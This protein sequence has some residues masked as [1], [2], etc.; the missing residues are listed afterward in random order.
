MVVL[1]KA[2]HWAF[3]K[4]HSKAGESIL[5]TAKRE[6]YEETGIN[7]IK[8]ENGKEFLEQ[9]FFDEDNQTHKKTVRYFIGFT[10]DKETNTPDEF[11]QEIKQTK[12]LNYIEAS[13]TLTFKKSKKILEEVKEYLKKYVKI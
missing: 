3:P 5:D 8:I 7:N 4:G 13:K 1:H 11:K 2:G 12:W 10:P 6:L 9:Y